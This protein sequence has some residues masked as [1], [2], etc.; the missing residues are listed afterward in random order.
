MKL[1]DK[2]LRI[3][4]SL[5]NSYYAR[6]WEKYLHLFDETNILMNNWY[7]QIWKNDGILISFAPSGYKAVV[8]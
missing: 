2:V 1:P 7:L 8:K 3:K 6:K 5:V 4:R